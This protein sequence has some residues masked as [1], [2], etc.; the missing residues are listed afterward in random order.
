MYIYLD[1]GC[2]ESISGAR[3]T[4]QPNEIC[5]KAKQ[6]QTVVVVFNASE[7]ESSL[8]Q[9]RA[10]VVSTVAFFYGDEISRQKYR[11]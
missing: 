2:K 4:I 6:T 9:E 10:A 5:L 8:C 3:L 7:R 1:L 11:K